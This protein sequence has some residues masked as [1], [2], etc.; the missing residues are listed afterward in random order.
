MLFSTALAAIFC[1]C[2]CTEKQPT[3]APEPEN[4]PVGFRPMSQAVMVKSDNTPAHKSLSEY[5]INTFG[6]WGI[7]R[8]SLN[9]QYLWN[10][11]TAN[12][13]IQLVS[14]TKGSDETYIPT[15][16]A[17]WFSH[18]THDFFALA[19]K[20]PGTTNTFGVTGLSVTHTDGTTGDQIDPVMT[21]TYDFSA[22]YTAK[23]YDYDL[24]GSAASKK[25]TTVT[26]P[27]QTLI[28]WHLFSK[29]NITVNFVETDKETPISPENA[30]LTR[31]RLCNVITKADYAISHGTD[32]YN[33]AL[34]CD[35]SKY[36]D[37]DD[38]E[39]YSAPA[40]L[41]FSNAQ[42]TF[43]I[44]PQDISDFK[45]YL[46]FRMKLGDQEAN[47]TDCEINL[48]PKENTPKEYQYN[49]QYNWNIFVS[50]KDIRFEVTVTSWKT[51][52]EGNQ[53]PS[54]GII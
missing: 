7:A 53:I 24:L 44:L 34:D 35:F 8:N 27:S 10:K 48:F 18:S 39:N 38:A 43:Y 40:E 22:K 51:P 21:F 47:F 6:V 54:I 33:L 1:L 5:G 50:K 30:S 32:A 25:I 29:I 20:E 42:Q 3:T 41:I 31:M 2:S 12:N 11:P 28:F 52:E 46:D 36:S 26:D 14:V 19:S 4:L 49:D 15:V 23:N 9:V 17:Y 37:E 45:L 13:A 16:D